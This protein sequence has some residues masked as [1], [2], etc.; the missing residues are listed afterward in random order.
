ML[1]VVFP[2]K[3]QSQDKKEFITIISMEHKLQ[4]HVYLTKTIH[5]TEWLKCNYSF[6]L[7]KH[8]S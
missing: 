3:I 4:A 8:K 6:P 1:L 5:I 2:S 7:L